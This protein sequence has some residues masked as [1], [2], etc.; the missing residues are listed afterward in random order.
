MG[1]TPSNDSPSQPLIVCLTGSESTGKTTLAHALAAHYRAPLVEEAARRYLAGRAEYGRDDVLAIAKEQLRLEAAALA[2]SPRLVICD[3]DLLVI[4]IW[5]EVKYGDAPAWLK[6]Q[7]GAG[8]H[9]YYLLMAPDF[10]WEPDPLR[11]S[12]GER[13]AL[14]RR[15][16]AVL[17]EDGLPFV[18][19]T[20]SVRRRLAVARRQID[21][22]LV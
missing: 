16:R 12:G 20:G 4:R 18:E 21:R 11:E 19:L 17:D 8:G 10:P 6:T 14:H 2:E 1:P 3:T 13:T 9:R 15:Y 5:L 22:L 7:P